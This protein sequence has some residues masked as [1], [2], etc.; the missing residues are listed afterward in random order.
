M[1]FD[2]MKKIWDEQTKQTMYAIDEDALHRRIKAKGNRAERTTKMNEFGLMAI[3]VITA[4]ILLFIKSTNTYNILAAVGML[5]MGVYVLIGRIR[6]LKKDRQFD[7]D[8]LGE[9]D[10]AISNVQNEVFRTRTFIWWMILP[11]AVPT[12]V[13][14]LQKE[15]SLESILLIVGAS[16]L[17]FLVTRWDLNRCQIPRKRELEV[18]RE[19]LVTETE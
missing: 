3:A 13:R 2:E 11:A 14:I 6:R 1:E 4:S 18:L 10:R 17:G 15:A 7:R 16:I 9:L 5:F 12:I 8:M 19:K